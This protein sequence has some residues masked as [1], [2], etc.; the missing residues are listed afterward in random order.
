MN[1]KR[2][3][4]SEQDDYSTRGPFSSIFGGPVARL[5][6][7]AFIVGNMEQ[8]VGILADSTNLSYKTTKKAMDKIEKMGYLNPTRKIG[9]A[10]AYKFRIE[11]HMSDLLKCGQKLQRSRK[12]LE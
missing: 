8:T 3:K 7:Q 4:L 5:I 1:K 11:N 2:E 6:D 9:N 12:D 10:Q